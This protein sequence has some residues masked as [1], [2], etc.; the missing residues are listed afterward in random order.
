MDRHEPVDV[1]LE[2]VTGHHRLNSTRVVRYWTAGDYW[3]EVPSQLWN[4]TLWPGDEFVKSAT[5]TFVVDD[6]LAAST[7]HFFVY[8]SDQVVENRTAA[9]QAASLLETSSDETSLNVHNGQFELGLN[10]LSGVHTLGRNGKNYH[11]NGSLSPSTEIPSEGLVGYWALDGS[12][13]DGSGLENH[14]TLVN[15]PEYRPAEHLGGCY[16]LEASNDQFI[17]IPDDPS[18]R[19][20]YLTLACWVNPESSGSGRMILNKEYDYELALMYN[21]LHWAIETSSKSWKWYGSAV[22]CPTGEWHHVALTYDGE[23]VKIYKDGEFQ[24]QQAYDGQVSKHTYPLY[25]GWRSQ[26]TGLYFDGMIDEVCI[27]DRALDAEEVAILHTRTL[28]SSLKIDSISDVQAGPVFVS[29]ELEW[30]QFVDQSTTDRVTVYNDLN[31]YRVE[32]TFFWTGV[33]QPSDGS[34]SVPLLNTGFATPGNFDAAV[35]GYHVDNAY[36]PGLESPSFTPEQYVFVRDTSGNNLQT[37]LGLF[38]SE[39]RTGRLLECSWL[40]CAV[41]YSGQQVDVV[42][43]NETDLDNDGP[44][45]PGFNPDFALTIVFWEFLSDATTSATTRTSGDINETTTL[46]TALAETLTTPLAR[47]V[48]AEEEFHF[49][50]EFHLE[51]IDHLACADVNLTLFN[52][53]NGE[54]FG[55]QSPPTALEGDQYTPR[56]TDA[57]GNATFT[58]LPAGNYSTRLAFRNSRYSPQELDLGTANFTLEHDYDGVTNRRSIVVTD[59]G[60]TTLNVH[61]LQVGSLAAI[62]NAILRFYYNDGV[63]PPDY[64]GNETTDDAGLATFRWSNTSQAVANVTCEV[65]FLGSLRPINLTESIPRENETMPYDESSSQTL[66]VHVE[67]FAPSFTAALWAPS[68]IWGELFTFNCTY[69]YTIS[70][71]PEFIP[72]ATVS[73]LLRNSTQQVIHGGYFGTTDGTGFAEFVLDTSNP[74]LPAGETYI[75]ELTADKTSYAPVTTSVMFTVELIPTCLTG[76]VTAIEAEWGKTIPVSVLYRDVHNNLPLGGATVNFS[77]LEFATVQGP[78]T[79]ALALGTGWYSLVLNTSEILYTGTYTLVIEGTKEN[80]ESKQL[81]VPITISEIYTRINGTVLA[82]DTVEVYHGEASQF[83]FNYSRQVSA[84]TRPTHVP[85]PEATSATFEWTKSGPPQVNGSGVLSYNAA[86]CLYEMDFHTELRPIG[87]YSITVQFQEINHVGRTALLVVNIV[88]RPILRTMACAHLV[89]DKIS[90]LKGDTTT[91]NVSALDSC[92]R[93]PISDCNVTLSVTTGSHPLVLP[94]ADPDHDGTFTVDFNSDW[95]GAF[96]QTRTFPSTLVIAAPNYANI[97]S[98]LT[99]EVGPRPL[100]VTWGAGIAAGRMALRKGEVGNVTVVLLDNNTGRPLRDARVTLRLELDGA[101]VRV[102]NLTDPNSDG[103]YTAM[104]DTAP[105]DTFLRERNLVGNLTV[106]AE[107]Y[108]PA[109]YPV[110]ISV[111]MTELVEGSGIPVFY[112]LLVIGVASAVLVPALIYRYV[113]WLHLPGV[114]KNILLTKKAVR[115]AKRTTKQQVEIP[116]HEQLAK[117]FGKPWAS[118][119]LQPPFQ[120]SSPLVRRF[121][122]IFNEETNKS[123]LVSEAEDYLNDI[124]IFSEGQV[125]AELVNDGVGRERLA[126]VMEIVGHYVETKPQFSAIQEIV[127]TFQEAFM[128]ITG[129]SLSLA[130]S[131]DYLQELLILSEAQLHERLKADGVPPDQF[132]RFQD[133]I[134]NYVS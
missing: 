92:T 59:V 117:K 132:S 75:L 81:L 73:Y 12:A 51:D 33:H 57:L 52:A 113:K 61:A 76:N 17:N 24:T 63:N 43:G 41:V 34:S 27:Y 35:D 53:T 26:A 99:L 127:T 66:T 78:A 108:A 65:Y 86:T 29:F 31:L 72:G 74:A 106:V 37:T 5:I 8:Y 93:A 121:T 107:N 49:V 44:H 56:L 102:L 42:A 97:T 23:W 2:F 20:S 112:F 105:I 58:R 85:V 45:P 111:G 14:G 4:L 95:L 67:N 110:Q 98:S 82:Y 87:T 46:L 1:Y 116:Y 15:D 28:E 48:G 13:Q 64:V 134:Q 130:E 16:D 7:A 118:L 125:K 3:T 115:K 36:Y 11:T 30:E 126:E 6:I 70:G 84:G 54:G 32:R 40:K 128:R 90:L 22:T 18:L 62:E 71:T 47:S 91:I 38:L 55:F 39:I 131:E 94:L 9:Y 101:E 96:D 50:V 60:L 68:R 122:S 119:G 123:L 77:V 120:K 133:L 114:V 69:A 21:E 89:N 109:S 104:L 103:I 100:V 79:P 88:P 124:T 129:K 83:A 80:H 25:L 10:E 19:V